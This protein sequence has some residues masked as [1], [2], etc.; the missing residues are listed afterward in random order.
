VHVPTVEHA[1]WTDEARIAAAPPAMQGAFA[2]VRRALGNL[3]GDQL[4]KFEPGADLAP[5]LTSIAAFGHTPGHSLFKMQSEG[6]SFAYVADITNVPSLFA[7][8]PDWAVLFDMNP[9]MAR[10]SRRRIFDMLVKEKMMA[11]GFH[12]PFPAFGTIAPSG[13]GY[14]FN[15][16]V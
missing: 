6:Q 8:A 2:A 3:S 10:Q 16:V 14:Q 12:F 4:V 15:P 9:E 11:G 1:F 13:D 7:R 5:G